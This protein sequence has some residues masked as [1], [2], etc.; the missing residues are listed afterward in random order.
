MEP[1]SAATIAV[2]FMA[3]AFFLRL[4]RIADTLTEIRDRLPK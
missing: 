4:G 1:M 3:V 2:M